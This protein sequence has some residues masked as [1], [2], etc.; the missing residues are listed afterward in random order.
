MGRCETSLSVFETKIFKDNFVNTMSIKVNFLETKIR[1]RC[2]LQKYL[3]I[4]QR[5]IIG[6]Y[7]ELLFIIQS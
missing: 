6:G 5:S 7:A 1:S 4:I 2:E 3:K